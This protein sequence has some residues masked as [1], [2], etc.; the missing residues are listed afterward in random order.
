MQRDERRRAR[1]DHRVERSEEES[2]GERRGVV[3]GDLH[4]HREMHGPE[5]GDGRHGH[6]Q[7]E[8][9]RIG[10]SKILSEGGARGEGRERRTEHAEDVNA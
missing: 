2:R 5:L 7:R 3:D 9:D 6:E 8:E 10:R 4:L 1:D